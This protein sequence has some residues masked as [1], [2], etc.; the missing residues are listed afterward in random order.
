MQTI[1]PN[2]STDFFYNMHFCLKVNKLIQTIITVVKKN[3]LITW[4]YWNWCEMTC[5]L[6]FNPYHSATLLSSGS[7]PNNHWSLSYQHTFFALIFWWYCRFWAHKREHMPDWTVASP[8]IL[9]QHCEKNRTLSSAQWIKITINSFFTIKKSECHWKK[10]YNFSIL[11]LIGENYYSCIVRE[12]LCEL[13]FKYH[14]FI[15]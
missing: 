11:S 7:F 2:T 3:A 10:N 5:S 13:P 6:A 9:H 14:C 12:F 15:V 1:I 8:L 4:L